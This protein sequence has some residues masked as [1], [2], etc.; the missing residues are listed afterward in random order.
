MADPRFF[1]AA[2]P[3]TLA[4][5]ARI[6]G[7]RIGPGGDE[8]AV[9]KD[10]APLDEAGADHVGFL[11]NRLYLDSFSKSRA[12]ACLVKPK[13]AG[14]APKGM[15]L[16]LS[17]NPY[18]ALAMVARAFY[19]PPP[20]VPGRHPASVVD[21]SARVGEDCR[22]EAGAVISERAEIGNRCLIEANAVIG[23]GVVV[24]DDTRIG[25]GASLVCCLLGSHVLIHPGVRIG[26]EGFGFAMEE[27]VHLKVAQL[28]RVIIEDDV[29][30]GANTTIDRGSGPDTVVGR[31]SNIDNLVQIGHNVQIGRGCV[32]VAQV[33]ISG[34]TKL[35]DYVVLGGQAGLTGHLHLGRGAKVAAN[36]G[37]MRNVGAGET[38]GGSPAMPIREWHRQ[39]VALSRLVRKKGA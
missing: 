36:S 6:S 33:G 37:V 4:E 15:A 21:P 32:I 39:T 3:F 34:S 13:Y 5:L 25:P 24:G 35:D 29:E 11:D 14:C 27:E 28:G 8:G 30:I 23:P 22:I 19:P 38:V 17:D 1:S 7:S 16:L 18:K 12:G 20:I 9:F 2:G 31:G 10:L 26:Q